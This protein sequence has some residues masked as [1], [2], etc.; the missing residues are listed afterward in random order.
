MSKRTA[1]QLTERMLSN[2]RWARG[3]RAGRRD[4]LVTT[5]SPS[6]AEQENQPQGLMDDSIIELE[7]F[8]GRAEL[9]RR[10]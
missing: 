6:G 8:R 10:P 2:R 4:M 3:Y 5:G 7:Y 1:L 9:P